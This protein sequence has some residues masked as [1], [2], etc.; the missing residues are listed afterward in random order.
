MSGDVLPAWAV[1]VAAGAGERLGG[2]RPKAFVRFAGRT[3]LAASLQTLDDHPGID[4]IVAVVPAGWEERTSL[5]VD[6]LC[7]TKVAAA[8]AGGRTRADSVAAGLA[9]VPD[10]AAFVLVHDAARPL[11]DAVLVERVLA[12]LAD[13]AD[14]VVPALRLADTVKRVDAVGR[15]LETVDR[16]ALRLAQT[17]QGFPLAVLQRALEGERGGAT[18]CAGLVERAGGSV[19]CVEGDPRN[20]K[21]T[22]PEDLRRAERLYGEEPS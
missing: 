3:L 14:G 19:V 22:T 2:E 6:D 9:C 7:A 18:D 5:L 8:V 4:G 17:P 16:D 10:S 21:V 11:L 1:V 13:G 15:V 20:L 12:A